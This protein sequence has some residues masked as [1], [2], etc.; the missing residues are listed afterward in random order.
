MQ[1]TP[2]APNRGIDCSGDYILRWARG[3]A[4]AED[5]EVNVVFVVDEFADFVF[6]TKFLQFLGFNVQP[7]RCL[8]HPFG[9]LRDEFVRKE[10]AVGH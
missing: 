9:Q 7:P 2:P 5:V 10:P 8:A 6:F 3:L 1:A 4:P